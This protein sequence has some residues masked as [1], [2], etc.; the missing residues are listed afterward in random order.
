MALGLA[1]RAFWSYSLK[2]GNELGEEDWKEICGILGDGKREDASKGL[3]QLRH[4]RFLIAF[5]SV[6]LM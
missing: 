3:R 1:G 2:Q 5:S 4:A 6:G